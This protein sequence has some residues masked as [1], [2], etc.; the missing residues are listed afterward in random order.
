MVVD[1]GPFVPSP[2][3]FLV[4]CQHDSFLGDIVPCPNYTSPILF[5]TVRDATPIV[6]LSSLPLYV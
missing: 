5:L 4:S 3:T 6:T 1:N 2:P